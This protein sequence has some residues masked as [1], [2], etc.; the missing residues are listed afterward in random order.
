[1]HHLVPSIVKVDFNPVNLNL[2]ELFRPVDVSRLT[3][4]PALGNEVGGLLQVDAIRKEP[5]F[6]MANM[7]VGDMGAGDGQYITS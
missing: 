4:Q 1:V 5:Q 7:E 6:A 3:D 2:R